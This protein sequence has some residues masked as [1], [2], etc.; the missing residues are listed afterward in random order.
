MA[1]NGQFQYTGQFKKKVTLSHFYIEVTNEP[2]ITRENSCQE[3]S[4]S[5]FVIDAGKCFGPPP[6][7]TVLQ[8][9]DSTAKGVPSF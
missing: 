7:E 5:L 4:Q 2:T 8:N 1:D 9:G 6:G 3:N